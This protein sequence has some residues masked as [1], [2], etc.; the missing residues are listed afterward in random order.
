MDSCTLKG[1]L[2]CMCEEREKKGKERGRKRGR[3]EPITSGRNSV[4]HELARLRKEE[5]YN[6]SA[7]TVKAILSCFPMLLE[8]SE[9]LLLILPFTHADNKVTYIH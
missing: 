5:D 9:P 1:L 6:V 4:D 8:L 3:G 7:H 2:K